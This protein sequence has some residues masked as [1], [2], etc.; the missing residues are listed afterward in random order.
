MS[1]Q[2][3]LLLRK[4]NAI[5][6]CRL[7]V[8]GKLAIAEIGVGGSSD[9]PI[10]KSQARRRWRDRYLA[11]YQARAAELFG[12]DVHRGK[13]SVPEFMCIHSTYAVRHAGIP[14][15]VVNIDVSNQRPVETDP[16]VETCSPPGM[17]HFKRT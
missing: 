16:A 4:R 11:S 1:A 6:G 5:D 2:T 14:V 3:P 7:A 13:V 15:S 12:S 9:R 17:N 8:A 10:R